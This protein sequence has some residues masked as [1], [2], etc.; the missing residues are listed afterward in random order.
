MPQS[1]EAYYQESGR[2]GREGQSSECYL[3]FTD[4]D[5]QKTKSWLDR[6][7]DKMG[8]RYD[9][10]GIVS[11]FHHD[12][13]P[14]IDTDVDGTKKVFRNLLESKNSICTITANLGGS[15]DQKQSKKTEKYLSYLTI[16]GIIKDYEVEGSIS[17]SRFK[18]ILADEV[19]NYLLNN[20]QAE[21]ETYL[22]GK[23]ADYQNRYR[24]T[25][26]DEIRKQVMS[27]H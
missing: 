17:N 15:L 12:N 25:T 8:K 4:D 6:K 24:P 3:I 9:D 2:A 21:L 18:I 22:F 27:I 1:L 13:F 26:S 20:D 5:P 7:I 23:L 10:L 11:F 19:A 16:L 14:G